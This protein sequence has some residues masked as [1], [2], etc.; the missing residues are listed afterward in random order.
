LSCKASR[1]EALK[2][3]IIDCYISILVIQLSIMV[4][5]GGIVLTN[6]YKLSTVPLKKSEF[7]VPGLMVQLDLQFKVPHPVWGK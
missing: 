6:V 1:L 4:M 2:S 7:N 3:G 5:C